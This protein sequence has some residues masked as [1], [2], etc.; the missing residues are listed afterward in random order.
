MVAKAV[1]AHLKS[2]WNDESAQGSTEYILLLAIVV[3]IAVLFKDKIK[4]LVGEK[5]TDLESG[6]GK[7]KATE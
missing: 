7:I 5:L 4:T 3:V 2:L 1:K 6:M